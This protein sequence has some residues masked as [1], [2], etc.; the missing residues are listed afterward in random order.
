MNSLGSVVTGKDGLSADNPSA[1]A[2][3]KDGLITYVAYNYETEN[4]YVRFSDGMGLNVPPGAF[5]VL[6]SEVAEDSE[7]IEG[8]E[9]EEDPGI[10]GVN[11][12]Q[13]SNASVENG[14]QHYSNGDCINNE[15]DSPSDSQIVQQANGDEIFSIVNSNKMQDARDFC[16]GQ[17]YTSLCRPNK[18]K[19]ER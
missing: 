6:T 1:I 13:E 14:E 3:E 16:K 5:R 2:F 18:S 8:S 10:E 17:R 12:E 15:C 9:A 19:P 11:N 7:D 4:Q